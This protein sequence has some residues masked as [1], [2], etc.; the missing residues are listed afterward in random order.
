MIRSP[1]KL[2]SL[3]SNP[4]KYQRKKN[5]LKSPVVLGGITVFSYGFPMGKSPS[6]QEL[7]PWPL[8]RLVPAPRPTLSW[9]AGSASRCTGN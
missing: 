1:Q 6:H 7:P 5:R 3:A 8:R 4:L 2:A 9:R